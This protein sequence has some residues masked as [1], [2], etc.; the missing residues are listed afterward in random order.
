M[1]DYLVDLGQNPYASKLIKSLGLPTPQDL[2]RGEGGWEAEPLIGQTA[3]LGTL[4]NSNASGQMAGTLANMGCDLQAPGYDASTK[5][6]VETA[7]EAG[8]KV[9]VFAPHSKPKNLKPKVLAFDA[10]GLQGPEDLHG[11][12]EFFHNN[13]RSIGTCGRAIVI[14]RLPESEKDLTA[15]VVARALEG[16][17]KSLGK[18]IGKKGATANLIYVE[19]GA[20]KMLEGPIRFLASNRSAFIDG[21]VMRVTKQVKAPSKINHTNALDGKVALVTGGARGIGAATAKRLAA[22]GAHVVCLDI[23]QDIETLNKTVAEVNGTALPMDITDKQAPTKIAEFL[24]EKFGGVDI[25]IHNAGVTRDKMIAN[26]KPH[27]WDMVININL[28]AILDIDAVLLDGIVNQDGRV[29]CLSSIGGIAGNAGQTNY[30]ATKAGVMGYVERQAPEVKARRI[31]VNAVA[32][33]FIETRMTAA[34]PFAIREAARRLSS[35]SQGGL[36]EDIAELICFYASP[37][38]HC[39]TGQTIRCCGQNLVGA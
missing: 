35:L 36:P 10:T 18:E 19:K 15:A 32:P 31:T 25:V 6:L 1:S 16:F 21:Q 23:P 7:E 27:L 30:G 33:G 37:G 20:E 4:V 11:L 14:G 12:Y 3:L 2:D 38:A 17:I 26:M 9:K 28:K 13:V 8:H 22:E 24:K 29:I 39:V 34:M 5:V